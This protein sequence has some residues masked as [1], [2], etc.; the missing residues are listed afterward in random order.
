VPS[1]NE[2]F[3]LIG[4][5]HTTSNGAA[6]CFAQ[7][8]LLGAAIEAFGFQAA[9]AQL[10]AAH[11]MVTLLRPCW[12]RMRTTYSHPGRPFCTMRY[13]ETSAHRV[14]GRC[15]S[16]SS[17]QGRYM[18]LHPA[19]GE[20]VL[21]VVAHIFGIWTVNGSQL[22]CFASGNRFEPGEVRQVATCCFTSGWHREVRQVTTCCF[23]AEQREREQQ[24]E[25]GQCGIGIRVR[26]R[27]VVVLFSGAVRTFCD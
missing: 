27:M 18:L 15:L 5:T 20:P 26:I 22:Y 6:L 8:A 23:T 19:H 10:I 9:S 13:D 1:S 21:M 17:K 24:G 2:H 7:P 14:H 11:A 3:Q 4:V 16:T 25:G 12:Q